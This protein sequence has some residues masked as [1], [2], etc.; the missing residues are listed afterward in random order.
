MMSSCDSYYRVLQSIAWFSWHSQNCQNSVKRVQGTCLV[1]EVS[2]QEGLWGVLDHPPWDA[3]LKF[4]SII[5]Q[6]R[7]TWISR[8]WHLRDLPPWTTTSAQAIYRTV[9]RSYGSEVG[10]QPCRGLIELEVSSLG[11]SKTMSP[12]M[13]Y[14]ENRMAITQFTL[15]KGFTG[16]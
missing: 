9:G 1:K 10:W 11:G 8:P 3:A 14:A 15:R 4:D 6:C 12:L 13:V 2:R 5:S 7:P 16:L